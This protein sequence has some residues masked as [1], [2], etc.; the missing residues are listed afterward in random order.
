MDLKTDHK[1]IQYAF[2][3][4]KL[5]T[6]KEGLRIFATIVTFVSKSN[7]LGGWRVVRL[8]L[9]GGKIP[10]RQKSYSQFYCSLWE[11]MSGLLG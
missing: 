7:T 3:I 8:S 6:K 10:S 2:A 4:F 11:K 1:K 5:T 9:K